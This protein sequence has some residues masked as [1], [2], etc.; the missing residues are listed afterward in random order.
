[1]GQGRRNGA[2]GVATGSMGRAA[3]AAGLLPVSFALA[4]GLPGAA[5][6]AAEWRI[7]PRVEVDETYNDNINLAPKGQEKSDFI[8]TI[9]PGIAVRGD[10]RRVKLNFDYD[11]QALF[12][13]RDSD[14]NQTRQRLRGGGQVELW[15]KVLFLDAQASINQQVVSATGGVGGTDLTAS[16]NLTTVQTY[17]IGPTFKHHFGPYADSETR[18]QFS[19]VTVDSEDVADTT[20]N[21]ASFVL[22]SGRYFA[23]LGWVLT[24]NESRT[25][26]SGGSSTTVNTFNNTASDRRLAKLDTQYAINSMFSLLAGVGYEKIKDVSLL[27]QPDGFLWDAGVQFRPNRVSSFRVKHGRRFGD[28]NTAV[29]I[30][31]QIGPKTTLTAAYNQTIQTSQGLLS[32]GLGF[33]GV[34]EFGR[35]VDT[36]T[37]LPFN[38]N[39]PTFGLNAGAFRQDRFATTLN[40]VRG[41][42]TFRFEVFEEQREFDISNTTTEAVGGRFNWSRRLTRATDLDFSTVYTH[43][44]Y[45]GALARD[46][47][48]YSVNLALTYRLS[49]SLRGTISAHRTERL[50]S[51]VGGDVIEDLVSVRVRKE[52]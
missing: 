7:T 37:G 15:E 38:P 24:L 1:M 6:T 51:A 11:P 16:Q 12:F 13:A 2:R 40:A 52:F 18:Y 30:S 10:G 34:D 8:T 28:P 39:D 33:V 41:R 36:R 14:N 42:N 43:T 5:A 44:D 20:S 19:A 45:S 49:D 29:D 9:S 32:G 47:D 35:L 17:N 31:Y 21:T 26:R 48:Y 27:E 46:D 23:N 4:A 22:R 25:D 3:W 50:S